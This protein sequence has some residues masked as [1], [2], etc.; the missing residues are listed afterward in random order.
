MKTKHLVFL[1]FIIPFCFWITTFICGFL[2]DDYNHLSN[3]VSELGAI[4]TKSQ[5]IF[6]TGLIISSIMSVLFIIGLYKTCKEIGLST[7]PI[8][9][10]LTF[11]FSICGAAI[12]PLPLRLH[13]ILGM[14][15]ILLF[16]SPLLSFI[17][18]KTE[19]IS[20]IKHI[21]LLIFLI[22]SLGFLTFIP[23]V[24]DNY[25]GLKQRFFH[26]GWTIWFFYLSS[27]F[28][29]LNNMLGMNQQPNR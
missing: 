5:Y 29:R 21:S 3:M 13:G 24:L 8:L 15:S 2:M 25:F 16:L 26:I 12:F 1:G 6:S 17:L 10:L 9:F 28:I 19:K 27:R 4:G 14:P 22:M 7:I 18:W 11:S 20:N 23:T